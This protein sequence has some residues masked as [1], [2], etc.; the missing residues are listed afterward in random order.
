MVGWPHRFATPGQALVASL[1]DSTTGSHRAYLGSDDSTVSWTLGGRFVRSFRADNAG[2]SPLEASTSVDHIIFTRFKEEG[3]SDPAAYAVALCIFRSD[4]LVIHY[5]SGEEFCVMLPFG[6]RAAHSLHGGILVQ[7]RATQDCTDS[8]LFAADMPTLFSL[9]SPRSEFKVLGLNRTLDLDRIRGQRDSLFILSPAPATSDDLG[10]SIPAFSDSNSILVGTAVGRIDATSQYVLCWDASLRRHVIYQCIVLSRQLDNNDN[11]YSSDTDTSFGVLPSRAVGADRGHLS[12]SRPGLNRQPSMSAQRRSSAAVSAAAMAATSRRKSRYS[13]AAKNDR[14]SSLLGRVLFNDSPGANYAADVFRE[15]RPTR[16]EIILHQCWT[17]RRQRGEPRATD[18]MSAQLFVIQSAAGDDVLCVFYRDIGQVV[19]LETLGFN[20]IFRHS[21]RS[22][23]PVR[24][25]RPETDDLLIVTGTGYVALAFGDGEEPVV[26]STPLQGQISQ[27]RHIEGALATLATVTEHDEVVIPTHVPVSRLVLSVLDSLSF[28]MSVASCSQLRRC[29]I[30]SVCQ[31]KDNQAQLERLAL[32]LIRGDDK[33]DPAV[34]LGA[35]AKKELRDRAAAAL[36]ALHLVF[37]D[38][39]MYKAESVSQLHELGQLLALFAQQHVAA[40][41]SIERSQVKSVHPSWIL[42]NWPSELTL[43]TE[44]SSEDDQQKRYRD[45]LALHAGFLLGMGLLSGHNGSEA[46]SSQ[47]GVATPQPQQRGGPLC[48]I[49]LWQTFRY[50]TIRHGLTS[51]ALLLGLACAHRGTMNSDVSRVLSLH[52]PSLLPPRSSER[53]L[54]SYGT[55][56]AAMLG[57]GLLFMRSQNR[58]MVEVMLC[59]L[60]S[61]KKNPHGKAS[62]F[63][64]S[65]DP[66]ESTVECCSLASGFALGLV[67]LGQ[68][69]S[70]QTLADL[71][72]LDTLSEMMSSNSTG[73][74]AVRMRDEP[75]LDDIGG[76]GLTSGGGA[77]SDLG[78]IAALG[79]AFLGTD[80]APAAQRLALPTVLQQLRTADPFVLLWKS[81]MRSLVMLSSIR[82]TQEWV[83]ANMPMS[84]AAMPD[85]MPADLCRV[86]LNVVSAACF[87]LALKYAGT[88]DRAAHSTILAYFDELETIASKPM[89]GYEP[90][91][92]RACAQACLDILCVSAALVMA[93]SGH[94]ATMARL[95]ALHGVSAS[96]LYGNHMASNMALGILFIGGGTRF[97]IA[98]S[99]DSIAMLVIALFPRFPQHY[100]DSSEHLQACRHIWALCVEPRCLVVR[101]VT[102]GKICRNATVAITRW[103]LAGTRETETVVPPVPFQLLAGATLVK[104]QARGY[105]PLELDHL[106]PV[107]AGQRLSARHGLYMQ[108]G[109]ASARGH[110]SMLEQYREWLTSAHRCVM[111]V[112]ERLSAIHFDIAPDVLDG[113]SIA[114]AIHSILRIRMCVQFSRYI[115][116]L[117]SSG[118]AEGWAE[119]TYATWM[120]VREKVL[121][122]AG[123]SSSQSIVMAYWTG[124][125]VPNSSPPRIELFYAVVGLLGA[126]LDL[127]SPA[128]AME[129]TKHIPIRHLLD[130]VITP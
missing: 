121:A 116:A 54:L 48:G 30:A 67:V 46:S 76:Q 107:V 6:V 11:Y 63:L 4:Q 104:L 127:P 124:S 75:A 120:S 1:D 50:L 13:S 128:H 44:T 98:R 49:P 43:E 93:G 21:A 7:S 72:L 59:E 95:R 47:I 81:L 20:E 118:A 15:Q 91:L 22:A 78:L 77:I 122:I 109:V 70:T 102:T 32:L 125:Q 65:S 94:V 29:V 100:A 8:G 108:P 82:P 97:T 3:S 45:S 99:H 41:L 113:V 126:A 34:V 62:S 42:L 40:A 55:Q 110:S 69:L 9:S 86:R 119:A 92:T 38:A 112:A 28:V 56:A 85:P 89:L 37:E 53:M 36:Y 58:R 57:L 2:K 25:I 79:L 105:L 90:S 66:A 74:H 117:P 130:Y 52:I 111:E 84:V 115:S 61:I 87:A 33:G 64:D 51:I 106:H 24:A 26:L 96:R 17:E 19:G 39:A 10:S 35:R 12:A 80:Y 68:G 88:E 101:D 114:E 83:E 14:R 123:Q 103:G 18:A 16:A 73:S 71:Q 27:I 23:A 129:L 31:A 60:S 5:Y